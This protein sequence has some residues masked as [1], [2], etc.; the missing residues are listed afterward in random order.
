MPL[1]F[2]KDTK[3]LIIL[4]RVLASSTWFSLHQ[5]QNN[6]IQFI[7]HPLDG[8]ASILKTP[9]IHFLPQS[10]P[11]ACWGFSTTSSPSIFSHINPAYHKIPNH[12]WICFIPLYR[13]FWF[14]ISQSIFFFLRKSIK[15]S[16]LNN[17]N[18][19]LHSFSYI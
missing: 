11:Y 7:L 8:A 4:V 14:I 13:M 19:I 2:Y 15:I 17:E 6:K 10:P 12:F 3:F 16:S 9:C 18:Y 5:S 1:F